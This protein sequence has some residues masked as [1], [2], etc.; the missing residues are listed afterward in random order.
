MR[1]SWMNRSN[2]GRRSVSALLPLL[3]ILAMIGIAC[4]ETSP[5]VGGVAEPSTTV[6][7]TTSPPVSTGAPVES[8]TTLSSETTTTTVAVVEEDASADPV[9]V[10]YRVVDVAADDVLNVRAGPSSEDEIVGSLAHD[11]SGVVVTRTWDAPWWG[12]LLDDGTEGWVHS[13][14]LAIDEAWTAHFEAIPCAA[15]DTPWDQTQVSLEPGGGSNADFVYGYDFLSSPDCDRLVIQLGTRSELTARPPDYPSIAADRVPAG[16]EVASA[17]NHVIVALPESLADVH[18]PAT[19]AEFDNAILAVTYGPGGWQDLEAHLV[20]DSER[21]AHA[22]FLDD[23]ARV[24]VDVRPASDPSGVDLAP[25][26]DGSFILTEPALWD[27]RVPGTRP[28]LTITGYGTA[29]ESHVWMNLNRVDGGDDH[30]DALWTGGSNCTDNPG[31]PTARGD[32]YCTM[33][34]SGWIWGSFA[35]TI[36]DLDP[37]TYRFYMAGECMVDEVGEE[38]CA[39]AGLDYEF[40][41][42]PSP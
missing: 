4:G 6:D 21:V 39:A 17:A 29:Y 15:S 40:V 38:A 25:Y 1:T 13:R 20:F 23:P 33:T 10:G 28:P 34:S 8:P 26:L 31:A 14:Y 32:A 19:T 37:G 12:V 5:P 30:I 24:V 7:S 42:H 41:V 36:D 9:R 2:S 18:Y 3:L 11:S 22:R 16:V 35:V 27:G